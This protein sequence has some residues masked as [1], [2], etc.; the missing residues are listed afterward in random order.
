MSPQT[1]STWCK[2]KVDPG[3]DQPREPIGFIHTWHPEKKKKSFSRH[4]GGASNEDNNGPGYRPLLVK[5]I[6]TLSLC[7]V[8]LYF[9]PEPWQHAETLTGSGVLWSSNTWYWLPLRALKNEQKA[10]LWWTNVRLR[11]RVSLLPGVLMCHPLKCN[12]TGCNWWRFPSSL[13]TSRCSPPNPSAGALGDRTP[14][15]AGVAPAPALDRGE[16]DGDHHPKPHGLMAPMFQSKM[17]DTVRDAYLSGIAVCQPVV[18]LGEVRQA[19]WNWHHLASC[20]VQSENPYIYSDGFG[21]LVAS[22]RSPI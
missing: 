6:L 8:V 14:A 5:A 17:T 16:D 19:A 12:C 18:F 2:R 7:L 20:F 9:I 15:E 1:G 4:A 3:F 22:R 10:H 13:K 11:R 21:C